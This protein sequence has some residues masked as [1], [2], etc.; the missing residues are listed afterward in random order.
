MP[1]ALPLPV[2]VSGSQEHNFECVEIHK[3]GTGE[4]FKRHHDLSYTFDDF[5]GPEAARP[6]T[7]TLT[8]VVRPVFRRGLNI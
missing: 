1:L 7:Q 4:Y 5:L 2:Q 8:W 6:V 3:T